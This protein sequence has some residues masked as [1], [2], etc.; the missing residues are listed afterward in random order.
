VKTITAPATGPAANVSTDN[1]SPKP[2]L[3]FPAGPQ[4]QAI[5]QGLHELS[6]QGLDALKAVLNLSLA[7]QETVKK[8]LDM[9]VAQRASIK[10]E[11]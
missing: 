11:L 4:G 8:I 10:N 5:L 1:S 9:E 2:R 6:P 3:G 7:E